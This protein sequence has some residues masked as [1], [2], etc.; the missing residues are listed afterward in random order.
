MAF[1]VYVVYCIKD[2]IKFP[3][4]GN[5]IITKYIITAGKERGYIMSKRRDALIIR[6]ATWKGY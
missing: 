3:Y 2:N 4:N 6:L 5:Y 1:I